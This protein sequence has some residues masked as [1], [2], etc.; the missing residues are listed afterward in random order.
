[1]LTA[2]L[3]FTI[4]LGISIGLVVSLLLQPRRWRPGVRR[5]RRRLLGSSWKPVLL[6]RYV[7]RA[8]NAAPPPTH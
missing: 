1:M 7:P 5:L 4:G 2:W 3:L 8:D 6:Q